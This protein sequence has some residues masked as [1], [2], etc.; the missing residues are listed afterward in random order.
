[1]RKHGLIWYWVFYV[2]IVFKII[3]H[4]IIY[5]A[6]NLLTWR[7]F[8]NLIYWSFEFHP[9]KLP[10][11]TYYARYISSSYPW[12]SQSEL[13]TGNMIKTYVKF[14]QIHCIFPHICHFMF[15]LFMWHLFLFWLC[16]QCSIHLVIFRKYT[17]FYFTKCVPPIFWKEI[18]LHRFFSLFCFLVWYVW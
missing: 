9:Q 18:L 1:M 7:P 5:W 16:L 8:I 10:W 6:E 3:V 13:W 15:L 12:F 4:F 17:I 14:Y 2:L 11:L